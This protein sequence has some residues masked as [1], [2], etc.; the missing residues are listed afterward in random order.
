MNGNPGKSE[1]ILKQKKGQLDIMGTA[2]SSVEKQSTKSLSREELK[3]P[4]SVMLGSARNGNIEELTLVIQQGMDPNE[5]ESP[6]SG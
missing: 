2:A 3:D 4:K 6:F 5:R 1:K